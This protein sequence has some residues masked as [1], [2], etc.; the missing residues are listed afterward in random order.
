MFGPLAKWMHRRKSIRLSA[1]PV[2]PPPLPPGWHIVPHPKPDVIAYEVRALLP[3]DY[4]PAIAGPGVEMVGLNATE[5]HGFAP[6]TLEIG[7][8]GVQMEFGVGYRLKYRFH[9][10]A[11]GWRQPGS[12]IP[13]FDFHRL[14]LGN[15]TKA[16]V[17]PQYLSFGN[18]CSLA[19]AVSAIEK[20]M[21]QE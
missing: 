4:R 5:F 15:D 21:Q 9:W 12:L 18:E 13:V 10:R 16:P 2:E 14:P 8:V 6:E 11:E 20:Q 17:T 19:D 3:M 7:S 1:P